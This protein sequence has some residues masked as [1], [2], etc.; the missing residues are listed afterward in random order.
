MNRYAFVDLIH[1]G[2]TPAEMTAGGP[3]AVYRALCRTA[4]SAMQRRQSRVEW[5]AQIDAGRLGQ[6]ARRKGHGKVLTDV[7]YSKMLDRVWTKETEWVASRP[8]PLGPVEVVQRIR[9]V[10]ERAEHPDAELT[11]IQRRILIH[12]CTVAQTHLTDRP[13][14]PRRGIVAASGLPERTVRTALSHMHETGLLVLAIPGRASSDPAKRRANLYKLP[15]AEVIRIPVPASGSMGQRTQVYGT[16]GAGPVGT[17]PQVYGTSIGSVTLTIAGEPDAVARA[18]KQLT[19]TDLPVEV[20]TDNEV[21]SENVASIDEA[22][23]RRTS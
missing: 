8:P 4:A 3:K 10:R 11:D 18:I 2:I 7:Q 12:A 9:D 19:T 16:P 13:A 20:T 14:L 1:N 6:Q 15:V 17:L 22:R 5:R 21:I 23:L